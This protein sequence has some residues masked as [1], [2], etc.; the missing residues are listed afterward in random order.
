MASGPPVAPPAITGASRRAEEE[1]NRI[2]A[3]LVQRASSATGSYDA[4]R[5]DDTSVPTAAQSQGPASEIASRLVAAIKSLKH[6]IAAS[7][8]T[9]RAAFLAPTARYFRLMPYG[10][11]EESPAVPA[12]NQH[13]S[14]SLSIAGVADV[15]RQYL[16]R[17]QASLPMASMVKPMTACWQHRP[18]PPMAVRIRRAAPHLGRSAKQYA[19]QSPAQS[20]SQTELPHTC[21]SRRQKP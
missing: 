17:K 9:S 16:R 7:P 15:R 11:A 12:H 13:A 2:D 20:C 6:I 5:A 4:E 14:V 21:F 18:R 10:D 1:E 3:R 8:F 19:R